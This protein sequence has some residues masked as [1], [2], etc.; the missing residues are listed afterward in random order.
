MQ[1]RRGN[2]LLDLARQVF[3]CASM[4]DKT[5]DKRLKLMGRLEPTN[6]ISFQFKFSDFFMFFIITASFSSFVVLADRSSRK[7][8]FLCH[9]SEKESRLFRQLK[10]FNSVNFRRCIT[11]LH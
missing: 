8:L 4:Y 2:G 9:L 3:T 6:F 5:V 1:T 10:H 7:L 11:K